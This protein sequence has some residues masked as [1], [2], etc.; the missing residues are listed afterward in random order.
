MAQ[1]KEFQA[2]SLDLL[3]VQPLTDTP[4]QDPESVQPTTDAPSQDPEAVQPLTD[5]PSQEPE[6]VQPTTDA[7]SLIPIDAYLSISLSVH[8]DVS[9]P[10]DN[11]TV[12]VTEFLF[13][14]IYI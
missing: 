8:A 6:S 5:A 3:S 2:L 7:P 4:S 9:V 12:Q 14:Y 1:E 11:E 10:L 13:I